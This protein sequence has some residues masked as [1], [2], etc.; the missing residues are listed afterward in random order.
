MTR[1]LS[2]VA[3][4]VLASLLSVAPAMALSSASQ[5]VD[6]T[7][8]FRSAAPSIADLQVFEIGGIVVIKGNA[9]DRAVAE[10]AGVVA[11]SLGYKRVANLVKVVAAPDDAAI[12]RAAEREL[13][14]DRSLDGCKFQVDSQNGVIHVAG[15][16]AEEIQKDEVVAVLRAIDGVRDVR[17]DLR[18]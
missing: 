9:P 4:S 11:E 1:T 5:P 16:V 15:K 10:R 3:G 18:R 13:T 6:I 2:L 12:R 8:Q 7:P 14:L 17:T